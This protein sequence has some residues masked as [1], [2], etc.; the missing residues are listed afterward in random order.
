[1]NNLEQKKQDIVDTFYPDESKTELAEVEPDSKEQPEE[2][3]AAESVEE[4]QAVEAEESEEAEVEEDTQETDDG[5]E[6]LYY[7]IGDEEISL[8][9]INNWREGHLRQSDYTKK[10]Q[11][12]AEEK[13]AIEGLQ[14][15][16]TDKTEKL[17]SLIKDLED[18][19]ATSSQEIDLD[20]LRETDPSEY[21]KQKE[22]AENKAKALEQAK[23]AKKA[24]FDAM[25]LNEQQL[26]IQSNPEWQDQKLMEAEVKMMNER[27]GELGFTKE[28]SDSLLTNHKIL[29]L[30]KESAKLKQLQE[31]KTLTEKEVKKA[32]KKVIKP[33][34]R[35]KAKQAAPKSAA[36]VFYT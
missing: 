9:E 29:N 6:S 14:T 17:D 12:L 19:I 23:E 2:T 20:Y 24:E 21:L 30:I 34:A 15:S 28:E 10:T 36:D 33:S 35:V 8:D 16:L 11:E 13:K 1:M 18:S 5:E 4:T 3:E 25:V 27:I 31:G 32:P 22:L 26:L 7:Q